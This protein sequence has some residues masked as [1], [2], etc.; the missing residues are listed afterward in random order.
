MP[1]IPPNREI[2]DDGH[3]DDHHAINAALADL[4]AVLPVA[5]PAGP[6]GPQGAVGPAGSAGPAGP[7]GAAGAQGLQGPQ[8]VRG[9]PGVTAQPNEPNDPNVLWLDTDEPGTAALPVGGSA[10]RALVK[11]S[12]ADYDTQWSAGLVVSTAGLLSGDGTSLGAWTTWTPTLG[13]TWA[14]GNGSIFGYYCQVGKI[15]HFRCAVISGGTTTFGTSSPTL[16]LPVAATSTRFS[17]N[18]TLMGTFNDVSTTLFYQT[19]CYMLSSTAVAL[20]VLGSNGLHSTASSTAPFTWA[21][22]DIIRFSGT[23]EAG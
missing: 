20:N 23:Y 2:G 17:Y 5:G 10:G 12:A 3:V 1:A 4:Q 14:I 13:N 6:Q 15:V 22:G 21:S 18:S 16:T 8:G 9:Y 7:Q 11:A 19:A